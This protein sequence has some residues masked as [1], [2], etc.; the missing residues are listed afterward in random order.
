MILITGLFPLPH[1]LSSGNNRFVAL[2][3]ASYWS[4]VI[5]F[6]LILKVPDSKYLGLGGGIIFVPGLL[7]MHKSL[8]IFS[9]Y[10]IQSAIYTSLICIIFAGSTSSYLHYK[11]G[12]VVI[13]ETGSSFE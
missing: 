13:T 3:N 11:N 6:L 1:S 8:G 7:L 2:Q 10:E 4:K 5:S 9:G 12:L